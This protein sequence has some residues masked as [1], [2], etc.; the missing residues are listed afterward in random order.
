MPV[1]SQI[2]VASWLSDVIR[3]YVLLRYGG[4]YLDTDMLAV[5]NFTPLM[6]RFDGN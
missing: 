6:D 4:V 5:H 3:Y 1:L 2:R